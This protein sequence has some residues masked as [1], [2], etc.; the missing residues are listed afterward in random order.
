[1]RLKNICI[2]CGFLGWCELRNEPDGTSLGRA[3]GEVRKLERDKAHSS[4]EY[5]CQRVWDPEERSWNV[6]GCYRSQWQYIGLS[7]QVKQKLFEEVIKPRRWQCF[8]TYNASHNPEQHLQLQ[9]KVRDRS[10]QLRNIIYGALAVA[11]AT[12][13]VEVIRWLLSR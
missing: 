2:E 5:V 13:L 7:D 3:V 10:D 9:E 6:L 12:S 4:S 11:G 1:M 8:I